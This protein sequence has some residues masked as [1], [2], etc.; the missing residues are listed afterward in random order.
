M[1]ISTIG[2]IYIYNFKKYENI[3]TIE[4]NDNEKGIFDINKRSNN[5][6][7]AYPDKFIG[8][9]KIKFYESNTTTIINAHKNNISHI[10]LNSYGTLISTASEIGTLIRIFNTNNG[11][12]LQEIRRGI[13]NTLIYDICFSGNNL[14]LGVSSN[15]KTIHIYSIEDSYKKISFNYNLI[16]NIPQNKTSNLKDL[17]QFVFDGYFKSEWSFTQIKINE[18]NCILGFIEENIL[19]TVNENGK[20]YMICI[21]LK[22]EGN[23]QI[24]DSN[25]IND[26]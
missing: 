4:T 14:L 2:K 6:I 18:N 10:S 13:D 11:D 16:K 23:Y 15:K 3:E 24:I 9:I 5:L 7:L 22:K 26:I 25:I 20:L 21:D 17:P 1:V 8:R 19:V 12:L